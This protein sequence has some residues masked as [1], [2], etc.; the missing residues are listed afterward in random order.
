[1]QTARLACVAATAVALA[2]SQTPKPNFTGTW[3]ADDSKTVVKTTPVK[4]PS[5]DA[6]EAPPPP[7][8]E[9][10]P[11]DVIEQNGNDLRIGEQT[12]TL[13][14][15]ENI[16]PL[17]VEGMA[18]RS[19]THWEGNKLVSDWALER[20]AKKLATGH[21]VRSLS[22][23][24]KTQIVETHIETPRLIIDTHMVMVKQP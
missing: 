13:D 8:P 22:G 9:E 23:D 1:M 19:T 2:L 11:P 20:D 12:F 15:K 16:N 21:R 24:G 7:P 10:Q 6:P 3:K 4:N 5:E 18:H 14:G 17:G